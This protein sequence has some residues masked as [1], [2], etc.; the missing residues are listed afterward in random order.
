MVQKYISKPRMRPDI[1]LTSGEQVTAII[2]V[3]DTNPPS[4][5]K[6]KKLV[7]FGKPTFMVK[8]EPQTSYQDG[9]NADESLNA[10]AYCYVCEYL[11]T[12]GEP[13]E[14]VKNLN[15]SAEFEHER[16]ASEE[17][18]TGS[19]EFA[20]EPTP[21]V[22]ERPMPFFTSASSTQAVN[23]RLNSESFLDRLHAVLI[24]T[25][26]EY[27]NAI[28]VWLTLTNPEYRRRRLALELLLQWC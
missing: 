22:F 17:P 5:E 11:R 28:D 27:R 18:T 1:A 26:P 16:V 23:N 6:R 25:N 24:L 2:E 3:V 7:R 8:A 12:A 4:I 9:F 10:V 20:V 15:T 19:G 13:Q 21:A 14:L